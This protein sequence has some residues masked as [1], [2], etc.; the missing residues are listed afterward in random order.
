MSVFRAADGALGPSGGAPKRGGAA[1]ERHPKGSVTERLSEERPFVALAPFLRADSRVVTLGVRPT[2]GDYTAEERRL[3]RQAR[4]VLFPT[5]R[6]AD[7]LEGGGCRCFPSAATYRYQRWR[8]LQW[9][10]GAFLN[11]PMVRSRLCYGEK[12]KREIPR[13]FQPPFR[14][15]GPRSGRD[16]VVL[17]DSWAAWEAVAQQENPVIVS[18][19]V[20]YRWR[21]DVW[22]AA[23]TV[24][25]WRRVPWDGLSDADAIPWVS[26]CPDAAASP[27]AERSLWV[28]RRAGIDDGVLVWGV[29]DGLEAFFFEGMKRPPPTL[30][31]AE[32]RSTRPALIFSAL[33]ENL[34]STHDHHE[35]GKQP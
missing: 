7:V 6:F 15:L 35:R 16:P 23:G 20:D 5:M 11:L 26:G 14:V 19:W 17:V 2:L 12:A 3:L 33:I 10:L 25:A 27:V 31:N 8:P 9:S 1:C 32:T 21:H 22:V 4:R 13:M 24:L 29:R 18:E 30:K 34:D 28:C